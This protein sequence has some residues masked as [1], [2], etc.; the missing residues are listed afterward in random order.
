M[1]KNA[2]RVLAISLAF[3]LLS[4]NIPSKSVFAEPWAPNTVTCYC[5]LGVAQ[6]WLTQWTVYDC[7]PCTQVICSSKDDQLHCQYNGSTTNGYIPEV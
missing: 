2:F 3:T 6:P 7:G 4:I 1:N 5:T